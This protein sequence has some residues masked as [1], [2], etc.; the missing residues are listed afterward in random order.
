V[1]RAIIFDFNG[2]IVDDE[3]IHLEGS[4]RVLECVGA[5]L[6]GEDYWGRADRSGKFC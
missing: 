3:Q 5:T 1:L 2:V 4:K 6:T